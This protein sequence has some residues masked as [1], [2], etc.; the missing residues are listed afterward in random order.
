VQSILK[1]KR[2][3]GLDLARLWISHDP[4]TERSIPIR[5]IKGTLS[6]TQQLYDTFLCQMG[7]GGTGFWL[8]DWIL[9]HGITTVVGARKVLADARAFENLR[10]R[11]AN[12]DSARMPLPR[13]DG[14]IIV[15]GR[16]MDLSGELDCMAWMCVRRQLDALF[17]HVL[18]YFDKIIVAGPRPQMLFEENRLVDRDW[19]KEQII[20][21][22]RVLLYIREVG[23]EDLFIFRDKPAFCLRHMHQSLEEAGLGALL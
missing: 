20:G 22:I 16:P 5:W 17:S 9:A 13:V 18:H 15:A 23:A 8:Q 21:L 2:I 14:P 7:N 4:G 19:I 1:L 11:A 6:S 12:Q 3:E 10:E